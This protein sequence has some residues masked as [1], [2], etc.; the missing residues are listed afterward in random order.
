MKSY[1]QISA[2]VRK[3]V[4]VVVF[5]KLDGSN[6]RVEWSK[7][8]GFYKFGRR[9]GLLDD[10]NPILRDEAPGLILDLYGDDLARVFHVEHW[11]R[12][13][14]FFEFH[15]PNSFAGNHEEEPHTVTL[16]DV[17]VHRKGILEPR[18]F[19]KLFGDLPAGVPRVLHEGNFTDGLKEEVQEGTLDGM[20]F[21]GVVAKGRNVSP[22][23]PLMFKWKSFAWLRRL[24]EYCGD[25]MEL[26]NRMR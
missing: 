2:G 6:I 10:S 3:G 1:P 26:F 9:N 14:A 13:I 21:E 19:L 25:N 8:R 24:K 4:P 22:G 16:I 12:V 20:T 23:R 18:K 5:D 7:K 17:S 11:Q 15:G